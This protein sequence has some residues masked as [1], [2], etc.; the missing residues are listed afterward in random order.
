MPLKTSVD[1]V[2]THIGLIASFGIGVR[3]RPGNPIPWGRGPFDL[4]AL[5]VVRS[6]SPKNQ[7]LQGQYFDGARLQS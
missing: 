7:C 2:E 1:L 6:L 4:E 5:P 3:G